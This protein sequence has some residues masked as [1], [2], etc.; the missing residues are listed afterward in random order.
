MKTLFLINHSH[1]DIGYT[2]RQEDIALQ[3]V[4]FIRQAMAIIDQELKA[5][6]HTDFVW[7]CE[8][9]WQVQNFFSE[10]TDA[11][12]RRF[13]EY[14]ERGYIDV[15]LN[16]FNMTELVDKDVLTDVLGEG[17]AWANTLER[18]LDSGMACDVN[19]FGWAYADALLDN[20]IDNFFTC[21][22]G[23]H[24]TPPLFE[25]QVPFWWQTA[26]GRKLLVWN[27]THYQFG[28][29]LYIIPG[30]QMS[31]LISD[32][33]NGDITSPQMPIAHDRIFNYFEALAARGY[34]YDFAPAMISG[35]VSDNAGPNEALL[36]SIAAWNAQ[37]GDEIRIQLIGLNQFFAYLRSQD[38]SALPTYRGDW[39]DWWADGVGSTPAATKIY[40]NAQRRYHVGQLLA[41][42]AEKQLP[43]AAAIRHQLML[44]AEHT[45]GYSSSV[46]EPWN[47]MVNELSFRKAA[48]ATQ[49]SVLANN[50]LNQQ[51]LYDYH[52]ATPRAN[53]HKTYKVI[54]PHD[55]AVDVP[56]VL[57]FE[58][59]ELLEGHRMC[60]ALLPYLEV[61]DL[62]TGAT[63]PRQI[64]GTPR[65]YE[66]TITAHLAPKETRR[67]AIRLGKNAA[68]DSRYLGFA[69]G[70]EGVRDIAHPG[71]ASDL[72]IETDDYEY[73]LD[74]TIGIASLTDKSTGR[75]LLR[76]D[77][78]AP[79]FYGVY[80]VTPV[81][82]DPCNER[83]RMGRNRK[84]NGVQ[85][86][87]SQLTD[88]RT[89]ADGP[90]YQTV[91]LDFSLTGTQLY[92]V[93]LKFYKHLPLIQTSVRVHKDS[94]W[95]PENLYVSLP[96][97]ATSDLYAEK[98]DQLFRPAIDQLPGTNADF[99]ALDSGFL[100]RDEAGK[101]LGVCPQDTPLITLG[102]L[103]PH[104][105]ELAGPDTA[106]KNHEQVFAWLMNNF[107]ET[108]FNVDLAGFYEFEFDLFTATTTDL[109]DAQ[110]A[111]RTQAQGVVTIATN[112]K[113]A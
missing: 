49:A 95:A 40:R 4:E 32:E 96:F 24:G 55:R 27:G 42:P 92:S 53:R 51:L 104:Q 44:Y 13:D 34:A 94:T 54:N 25:D 84:G 68:V 35:Y 88:I 26:D 72:V 66:V 23:H 79:A 77:A 113:G 90:V 71:V 39:N 5:N 62:Q 52:M 56:A 110:A 7:T 21:V 43:T 91:V 1:T 17:R 9:Y 106:A 67:Y 76:E 15:S 37:Y 38:L 100:Y 18:K 20:Q 63:V 64:A 45:W 6:G 105:I 10:A 58:Y 83:R 102:S 86:S 93:Q 101:T 22:H 3:H 73:R 74:G 98:I 75:S 50:Y 28:D 85:R 103:R 109:D 111:L 31:Y 2:D 65:A 61:V 41:T 97:A 16:A 29:E 33:H 59:P 14:V 78:L 8:N 60:D 48:F 107:W 87:L 99:W 69:R 36:A 70:T 112:E 89:I 80:E 46:S 57:N 108:N 11:E 30:G 47:T 81:K 82:T 12:K 19:G